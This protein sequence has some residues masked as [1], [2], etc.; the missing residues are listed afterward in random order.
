MPNFKSRGWAEISKTRSKKNPFKVRYWGKNGEKMGVSDEPLSTIK[1]CHKNIIAHGKMWE[2]ND[3][4]P[5]INVLDK[6]GKLEV[7][8]TLNFDGKQETAGGE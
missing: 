2:G 3:C 5:K 7:W 6:T 1:N 8:Y 4:F